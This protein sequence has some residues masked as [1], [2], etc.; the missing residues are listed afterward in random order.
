MA[1][2]PR[3]TCTWIGRLAWTCDGRTPQWTPW[4][5]PGLIARVGIGVGQTDKWPFTGA[6]GI[7]CA[8]RWCSLRLSQSTHRVRRARKQRFRMAA[9]GA[10]AAIAD[11]LSGRWPGRDTSGARGCAANDMIGFLARS[12]TWPVVRCGT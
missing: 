10:V 3:W 12:F 2:V 4:R 11:L 7:P 9:D 6:P 5:Y 8:K 1:R